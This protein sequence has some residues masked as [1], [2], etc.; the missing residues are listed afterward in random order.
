MF[1]NIAY[2]Y[3][4]LNHFLSLGIDTIWRRKAINCLKDINPRRILDVASGTADLA[5]EALR[6][7]PDEIIGIDICIN[8][9]LIQ[10]II[11]V[12]L[13]LSHS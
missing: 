9:C 11:F 7:N 12:M 8:K 3:D 2:R 6:L 4:F 1:N 13:R 10:I 5:I